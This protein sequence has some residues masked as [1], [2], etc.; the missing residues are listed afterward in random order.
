MQRKVEEEYEGVRE[1]VLGFDEVLDG[2][3]QVIYQ[4]RMEAL[5]SSDA[6]FDASFSGWA[7]SVVDDIVDGSGGDGGKVRGVNLR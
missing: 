6:D 3:R 7:K 5:T 2:Q 1:G 4:D